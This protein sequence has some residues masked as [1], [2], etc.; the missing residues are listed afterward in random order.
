MGR[1]RT[2]KKVVRLRIAVTV[3]RHRTT[4]TVHS[5]AVMVTWHPQTVEHT[6]RHV[7]VRTTDKKAW[8]QYPLPPLSPLEVA[9]AT[10]NHH[11]PTPI[12]RSSD[13]DTHGA[14]L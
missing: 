9:K 14:P 3:A 6:V 4:A 11:S 12:A 2:V 5:A 10:T 8:C 7:I 1:H 13:S